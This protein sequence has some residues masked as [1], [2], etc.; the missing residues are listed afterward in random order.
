[1]VVGCRRQDSDKENV[2]ANGKPINFMKLTLFEMTA[3]SSERN[4]G[5]NLG[6]H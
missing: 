1:M 6:V 3:V 5:L 4:Y 2:V